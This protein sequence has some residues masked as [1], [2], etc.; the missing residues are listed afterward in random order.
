MEKRLS[1]QK[2]LR[3]KTFASTAIFLQKIIDTVG[4][5]IAYLKD[6]GTDLGKAV[7]ILDKQGLGSPS[8]NDISHVIANLLKHEYETHSMFQIFMSA[9]GK[10]STSLKQTILACLAPP[11]V[12][13]KAR[14]MNIHRLVKW[15][16]QILKHSPRG[17]ASTGSVLSKLRA[18]FDRLPECKVFISCFL[19]DANALL[20]CQKILKTKGLNHETYKQCQQLVE[21]IPKQSKVYIGFIDWMNLQLSVAVS[22]GLDKIGMPISSDSIE[23][24]F[25]VAKRHG[26][27]EIQ[28]ANQ[29]A[30]RIPAMS[31]VLTKE[32]AQSVLN[33][34]VKDQQNILNV[35]PSIVQQR[36]QV[37]PNPGCLEKLQSGDKKQNLE[38]IP[39]PKTGQ[40]ML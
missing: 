25:S 34:S 4:M 18:G 26:T 12:S 2:F 11:K 33:I 23:S 20:A 27:G 8:I 15:A 6:G 1:R 19:R 36:R 37:L 38:L 30:L 9:C 22:L 17:R 32:D 3:A 14:F 16:S 21:I 35:F 29:I 39:S 13:T 24:F 5:P 10:V 28:D 7:K 40:K 31:G